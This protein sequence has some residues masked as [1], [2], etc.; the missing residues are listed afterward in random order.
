MFHLYFLKF[1]NFSKKRFFSCRKK[2]NHSNGRYSISTNLDKPAYKK[3]CI[4]ASLLQ[5]CRS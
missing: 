3:D 2:K 1:E 4:A 5:P